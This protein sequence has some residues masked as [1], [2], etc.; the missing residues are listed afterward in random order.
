M[1]P[2][3]TDPIERRLR[4]ARPASAEVPAD[5]ADGPEAQAVLE[6]ARTA[7]PTRRRPRAL[8]TGIAVA[9][10]AL[11]V[12]VV[13]ALPGADTGPDAALAR[14][15][16][17][18][19]RWFD[20]TPGTVLH[21]RNTLVSTGPGGER[22]VLHQ[23]G[24][25]LVDHPDETRT[26][27]TQDGHRSEAARDGL[28]DPATKTVYLFVPPSPGDLKRMIERKIAAAR[29]GGASDEQIEEMRR[30]AEKPAGPPEE[31]EAGDPV[32]AK[33]RDLLRHGAAR[34]AGFQTR[35][36]VKTYAIELQ[37]ISRAPAG[38]PAGQTRWTLWIAADDGRPLELRIDHG[39]GTRAVE[40]TTW[41]TYEL[42]SGDESARLVTVRG[43][44][45]DARVIRDADAVDEATAR[46]YPKG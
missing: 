14:P 34:V 31:P 9:L 26:V 35:R 25:Q 33:V 5:A 21:Y 38:D 30:A 29:A 12:V 23:E 20:P 32:T 7:A 10:A 13:A 4:A 6:R 1:A 15:I 27:S 2:V 39:P 37:P 16:K 24:W 36:G 40:T 22:T 3:V 17:L 41:E 18:A 44:H 46:L 42:L 11:A 43:A 19:F 45:R 28:Y 8:R